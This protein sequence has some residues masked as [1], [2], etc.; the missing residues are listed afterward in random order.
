MSK[1]IPAIALASALALIPS[2]A[3]A[4]I[5]VADSMDNDAIFTLDESLSLD[6]VD[7]NI[8]RQGPGCVGDCRG[9]VAPGPGPRPGHRPPPPPP[10]PRREVRQYRTTTVVRSRPVVVVE[11][12]PTVV[13]EEESSDESVSRRGSI[14]GFGIRGVGLYQGPSETEYGDCVEHQINGG[15]GYY[16]KFRPSRFISIEF[17]NDILFGKN[18]GEDGSYIKVPVSLGLR[19]HVFDYGSFDLYGVAAASVSFVSLSDGY[20]AM[21]SDY[22]Y[23]DT[24]FALFGGQFGVGASFIAGGFEIGLDA[25]YILEQSAENKSDLDHGIL[26]S[27]NLGF[28]L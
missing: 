23:D 5:S 9:G 16:I 2:F 28:A 19:G 25:R 4:E 17:I 7:G 12:P 6:G 18:K 27:L 21:Y 1:L 14:L 10:G 26:F 3:S 8:T 22:N 11:Q 13:V 20:N 24:H 15:A